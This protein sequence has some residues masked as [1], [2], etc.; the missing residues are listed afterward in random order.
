[1]A[2][3]LLFQCDLPAMGSFAAV[4]EAGLRIPGDISIVG[5]YDISFA[6]CLE[7]PLTSVA[8]PKR[9]LAEALSATLMRRLEQPAA[10]PRH[11]MIAPEVRAG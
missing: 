11:L 7:P 4:R 1:M 8:Q 6:A 2:I 3:L 9:K 10:P 5:F